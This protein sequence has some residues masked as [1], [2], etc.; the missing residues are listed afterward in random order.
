MMSW[1]Y[2]LLAVSLSV[3]P[4]II[5]LLWLGP[6]LNNRYSAQWRYIMW[7]IISIRLLLPVSPT[8]PVSFQLPVRVTDG[9]TPSY[10]LD[11]PLTNTASLLATDPSPAQILFVIYL[12]GFLAYIFYQI[13]TYAAF[14]RN[15]LRCSRKP[16][17]EGIEDLLTELKTERNI[18]R[19]IPVR[20]CKK[21]SSPMIVGLLNPTL[22]LP[23]ESFSN[24]EL[25]MILAHE[26]LH[27][28]R[29][30]LWYKLVLMITAA[31]HWFNPVVH[32]MVREASQDM[33]LSCDNH[34]LRGLDLDAKKRYCNILLNLAIRNNKAEGPVLSTSIRSSKD[35]LETRIKNIFDSTGKRPGIV[36]ITI[37]AVWVVVSGVTVDISGAESL[38][39][40]PPRNEAVASPIDNQNGNEEYIAAGD[41]PPPEKA[42]GNRE[43]EPYSISENKPRITAEENRRENEADQK[44]EALTGGGSGAE[45]VVVDLNRLEKNT[46]VNH[47]I[48]EK[49]TEI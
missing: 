37:L 49:S 44:A 38:T 2:D 7:M 13:Y 40:P 15:V 27:L 1:F 28:Q 34:V 17:D 32:L 47:D 41:S 22:I 8:V 24:A 9:L 20:I 46:Q 33:E 18:Q 14:R 31:V 10:I 3:T 43:A 25:R 12:M 6:V 48:Q 29:H 16:P 11:K 36:A 4:I 35:T 21:V 42:A 23:A 39:D 26:L 5:L 19:E 30:D 45:V